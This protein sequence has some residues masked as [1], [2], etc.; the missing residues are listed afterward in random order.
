[1][2]VALHLA[3]AVASSL[4]LRAHAAKQGAQNSNASTFKR[5]R[6]WQTGVPG[7]VPVGKFVSVMNNLILHLKLFFQHFNLRDVSLYI[8]LEVSNMLLL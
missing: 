6:V 1:M 8:S 3:G 2:P 5:K 7:L 4:F